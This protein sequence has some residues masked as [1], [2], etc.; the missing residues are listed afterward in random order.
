MTDQKQLAISQEIKKIKEEN[1][2]MRTLATRNGFFDR[3]FKEL[4][5]VK[6]NGRPRHRTQVEC[7]NHIN[8][9][10]FDLFGEYRYTDYNSF[11]KQVNAH[12]RTK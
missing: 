4:G 2:L 8:D 1:S 6:E 11:R 9:Q 10:Y 12:H 3:Y 5:S 7:F